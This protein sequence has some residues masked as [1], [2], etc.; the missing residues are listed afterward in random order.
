MKL[1]WWR[2][3]EVVDTADSD[4]NPHA[5]RR[6]SLISRAWQLDISGCSI[7]LKTTLHHLGITWWCRKNEKE[8]VS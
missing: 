4:V 5:G 8:K 6:L 7:H 2:G 1:K 3:Y